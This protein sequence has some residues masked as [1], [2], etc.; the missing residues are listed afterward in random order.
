MLPSGL[1]SRIRE[2][3]TLYKDTEV[4]FRFGNLIKGS[5][6]GGINKRTY[7]R[8][9]SL[10]KKRSGGIY[11][12]ENV[13]DYISGTLRKR[14]II[15]QPGKEGQT[16]WFN[17]KSLF[18][19]NY[20]DYPVRL[21]I[22]REI[23]TQEK[24]KF[25][26]EIIRNKHRISFYYSSNVF[27][28]DL[29]KVYVIER[30]K[31]TTSYEM[32][33]E[34]LN[35]SFSDSALS[36][37]I[38]GLLK[39]LFDTVYVY[40]DKEKKAILEKVNKILHGRKM[41]GVDPSILMQSRNLKLE[42][43]VYGGLMGNPQTSYSVTHKADGVRK[44]LIFDTTGIWL[45]MPPDEVNLIT[46]SKVGDFIGIVLDG[47]EIPMESR[48]ANSPQTDYWYIAF[49][50]LSMKSR[51][52][53][54]FIF[55]TSIQR[56]TLNERLRVCETVSG[57]ESMQTKS[58]WVN[59]KAFRNFSTPETFFATMRSMFAQQSSLEYKQDG[60]IFTALNLPYN[61]ESDK[62]P[63]RDRI[64]S[65]IPD[66]LK[67]KP[68]SLL[69][70]DLAV[71]FRALPSGK[72]V[73]PYAWK[74]GKYVE[75]RGDKRNP[76]REVIYSNILE[77]DEGTVVEFTVNDNDL[78]PL[79]VRERKLP[80]RLE[81]AINIWRDAHKPLT[82]ETL[83]GDNFVLL[84]R[85]HNNIKRNLLDTLPEGSTLLDL[86]SGKGAD[87]GKWRHLSH[88]IAVEPSMEKVEEFNSRLK[89]SGTRNVTL[90]QV[91]AEDT[92]T[93]T[94]YISRTVGKVDAV[95]MLLSATF[96]W[97]NNVLLARVI[98][99]IKRNL[100]PEG[101]LLFFTIDGN[102]V[103]Q[104]FAPRNGVPLSSIKLGDNYMY[105]SE[106]PSRLTLNFPGTIIEN[107]T[108]PLVFLEDIASDFYLDVNRADKERFLTPEEMIFTNLYVYGVGIL[109]P[110]E[111]KLTPLVI[112]Y[113]PENEETTG[114]D[115][116]KY[117]TKYTERLVRIPTIGMG[118]SFF[119]ALLKAF[120]LPY[121]EIQHYPEKVK[122]VTELRRD[123]AYDLGELYP[124][125]YKGAWKDMGLTKLGENFTLES[126]QKE[127][128]STENIGEY[129]YEY[130][131]HALQVDV[132]LLEGNNLRPKMYTG[133]ALPGVI[134]LD[135][136]SHIELIGRL[137]GDEAITLFEPT[138]KILED[139]RRQI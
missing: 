24:E 38:T 60:F 108:E 8:I 3:F 44:L 64:L 116:V 80:N 103:Q 122:L 30:G 117:V 107:Q 50:C 134:L 93:I 37:I 86:G 135:L 98:E 70:I 96:F 2:A 68:P 132:Y 33:L 106:N 69:T 112:T 47:E 118:S 45:I 115:N 139:I 120:N 71:Q 95:S 57:F 48:K 78:I 12:E 54:V 40:T 6:V 114:E 51:G 83:R 52:N 13:D 92:E 105:Y 127:L 9:V 99:T 23:P 26:A 31:K 16:I 125:V 129:F 121:R 91:P 119:H 15:S 79:R 128:N 49:D 32:E 62:F 113:N 5:Y 58:L 126:L 110:E 100:K 130:I 111:R 55:D 97:E 88:V 10:F 27:R 124:R 138:N 22:S 84:R 36:N 43:M 66:N 4:E 56:R 131:A 7:D 82:E 123:L 17:K 81:V 75:F 35:P 53:T 61:T 20:N 76:L 34:I 90:L 19:Y 87:I 63:I 14:V 18:T 109:K 94:D 39:F 29:T 25:T 46:T 85:Y 133:N 77:V 102:A 21:S 1:P 104:T 28:V 101:K 72:R 67:W 137:E 89:S 59:T 42:D 74:K 73:V 136:N 65:N 41:Y 11:E